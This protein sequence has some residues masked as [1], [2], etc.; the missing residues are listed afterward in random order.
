MTKT[1]SAPGTER[2]WRVSQAGP[3]VAVLA[4]PF[5]L[6]ESR[7]FISIIRSWPLTRVSTDD[8]AKEEVS[9]KKL[10]GK[11]EPGRSR[12]RV[13]LLVDAGRSAF[14]INPVRRHALPVEAYREESRPSAAREPESQSVMSA[15][16]GRATPLAVAYS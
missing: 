10:E 15:R 3:G 16:H 7:A 1:G 13:M 8:G 9:G 12:G 6:A 14:A 4:C 2:I 11:P 5:F